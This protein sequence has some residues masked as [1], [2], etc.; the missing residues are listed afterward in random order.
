M[1]C[2]VCNGDGF[3]VGDK[4]YEIQCPYCDGKGETDEYE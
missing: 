2:P 4:G 3:Y 1:K